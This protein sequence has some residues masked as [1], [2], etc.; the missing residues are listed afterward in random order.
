[1]TV[2]LGTDTVNSVRSPASA[3]NIVGLRPTAGLVSRDGLL[4]LSLSQDVIG[5][6][7]RTVADVAA[8]LEVIAIDDAN[9]PMTV[10]RAGRVSGGYPSERNPSP[11]NEG[12]K[13]ISLQPGDLTPNGLKISVSASCAAYS[14]RGQSMEKSMSLWMRPLA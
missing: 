7:G 1:M 6:M 4:S 10:R 2:G 11:Q 3:C 13:K 8:V 5:P 12:L 9:D 14:A